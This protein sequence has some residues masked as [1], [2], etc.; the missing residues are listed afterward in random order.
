MSDAQLPLTLGEGNFTGSETST[1][2][3]SLQN[4][5]WLLGL[6]KLQGIG[7]KKAL[8]LVKHFVTYER[9]STASDADI[10]Q[11]IGKNAVDFGKLSML[12]V[13]QPDDVKILT[14]FDS[15]YPAGLRDLSDAPLMLWYRGVI[16]ANKS[17]AIVGTRNADDWGKSTTRLLA[18]MCGDFDFA[19][20]SGLALGVD[21]EAHLGCLESNAPT[22]GILACDVRFPTPKSN[23]KLASDILEKGGCL[24]AEVPPGTETESF[25][26]VARNRLQAAWSQGLIMTQCG[27]PSGTLHTVRFAMELGRELIV[28]EPP[29]NSKG[30]QYEGNIN[31]SQEFKFDPRILGGSKKFQESVKVRT[32]A[33]D[34]VINS[35]PK[36]EE[37][38]KNA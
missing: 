13:D 11:V 10:R 8:K 29:I 9:L 26:L 34:V 30:S 21:T 23:R 35:V 37:F 22:V 25:A 6:L 1:S 16:P 38:L 20:I 28:L 5:G 4:P 18:K 17:L 3:N 15:G 36:F 32:R 2:A 19:V 7:S 14:Y 33:A 24:I 27:I 12:D 31:L